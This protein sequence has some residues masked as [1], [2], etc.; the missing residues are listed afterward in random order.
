MRRWWQYWPTWSAY[1]A[2]FWSFGYGIAGLYWTLGGAGFPFASVVS[3]RSTMSILEGTPVAIVGPVIATVGLVGGVV[4]IAMIRRVGPRRVVLA[5]GWLFAVAFAL[6]IP[7]YSI[8]AIVALSPLLVVFAFTGVP[9]PQH[10]L[11]AVLYWHRLNLVLVFVGGLLWAAATLAYQRRTANACGNCGRPGGSW[12]ITPRVGHWAVIVA[13]AVNVPYEVTRICWYFGVPLGIT[14]GFLHMMQST[15]H[16]LSVGL[17]LA[18]AGTVGGIL[19]H[20]LVSRWG[21]VYPRWLWFKAGKPVAPA[22]AVVPAALVAVILIPAGLMNFRLPTSLDSWAV[23]VPGMLWVVWG[24]ALGTATYAYYLRRR[25]ECRHCR[26]VA[27]TVSR[28]SSAVG[29]SKPSK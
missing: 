13:V 26:Q 8:L 2:M 1:L 10:D 4:G 11:G 14:P 29:G 25:P 6:I 12:V 22:V 19:T 23:N 27:T 15:P 7:D 28:P 17:G 18:V 9:G 21:E 24:A 20:G 16:M 3:D 5:L